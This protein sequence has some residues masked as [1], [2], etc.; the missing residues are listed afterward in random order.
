MQLPDSESVKIVLS[1]NTLL[2][3]SG[4]ALFDLFCIE[5]SG[6]VNFTPEKQQFLCKFSR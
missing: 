2:C 4:I 5:G 6:L 3:M 1:E